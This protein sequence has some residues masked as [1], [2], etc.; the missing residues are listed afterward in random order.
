[1]HPDEVVHTE[2]ENDGDES[3]VTWAKAHVCSG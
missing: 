3:V 1:V 2:C